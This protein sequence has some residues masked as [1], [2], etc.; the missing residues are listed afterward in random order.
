MYQT[1]KAKRKLAKAREEGLKE[2]ARRRVRVANV[3]DDGLGKNLAVLLVGIVAIFAVKY[4]DSSTVMNSTKTRQ[5]LG[6]NVGMLR[7]LKGSCTFSS[8][9][10]DKLRKE[11]FV[12][13]FLDKGNLL[14]IEDGNTNTEVNLDWAEAFQYTTETTIAGR[15]EIFLGA[16]GQV[17][18]SATP[19]LI[20]VNYD[21]VVI[22]VGGGEGKA[23][24]SCIVGKGDAVF[25]PEDR[26][27]RL[28]VLERGE[29]EYVE[30]LVLTRKW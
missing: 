11:G 24:R 23:D 12:A 20:S 13:N 2:G 6:V 25:V 30:D 21:G 3:S 26:T 8:V 16:I 14:K 9:R 17:A 28:L 5:Q 7:K 10:S 15:E 4:L 18:G 29:T 1:F 19:S 27:A 22:Q